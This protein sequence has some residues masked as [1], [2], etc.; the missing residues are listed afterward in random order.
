MFNTIL[1][2]NRGEIA[3]RVMHTAQKMGITCVA[4][5]SDADA[6]AK[7]VEMADKAVHIGGSAPADSYLKGDVIIQAALDSGAQAIHPGYGFL[8]ENPD[9]VD[10]VHNA[11]LTFIGPSGD[12]IRA[13]GL[14]DAAKVLMEKAGVP[15]VPGYHGANQDDKFLAEQAK[16]IT[17]PVL[18]KAVAGG[19]GKGM[20]LVETPDTFDEALQ[21]AR[22]E[23]ATAF[24]NA[25]VLVEKYVSK[26]RHIEIQIFGDGTNAVHLFERDCSL[27]RRHQKVIEEAPAPGMTDEMR[28]AMGQAG[29]RAAEAIGYSGAGTVEF[30]VD[31]SDGLRAD[32]FW[33]ME[34]NTRLQ[35]EHPV[36][37]AITGVDLVEWQLRVAAGEPLPKQQ[38]DLHISGHAFE[39]RLYA[40]DVP[41]GFLPA[42]GTLTHLSFP[43]GARAD[44]GV[45]QGD[46]ISPWYDPMIAKLVVHGPNR[47]A[48]LNQLERALRHTDVGGLTTNISFLSALAAQPDFKAGDMDTGL[49]AR[50]IDTLTPPPVA[51]TKARSIAALTALGLWDNPNVSG[52]TLW[53]PLTRDVTLTHLD[54]DITARVST[55]GPQDFTVELPEVSPR[56]VRR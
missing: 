35:V 50:H 47:G 14:K 7:H 29:V 2:A 6:N 25:D 28:A 12:A 8:S 41:A 26:P 24:G 4:V 15:V 3:V 40:E 16:T 20:R 33:F 5:Y 31:A 52:F 51:C 38:Q 42:T 55:N 36:T 9:F 23:A 44:S 32:R 43:D 37:E 13:M 1:I 34:M 17:Y 39:A 22:G 21:S 56:V 10:A 53:Q 49:I 45:R 54:Q 46:T 18:I 11:G 19:G 48:A 30:I 27:Q